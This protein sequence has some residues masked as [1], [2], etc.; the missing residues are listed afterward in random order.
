[1]EKDFDIKEIQKDLNEYF[2]KK[3]GRRIQFAGFGPVQ[4]PAENKS[5]EGSKERSKEPLSINFDMKPEELEVASALQVK[6][7]FLLDPL[8]RWLEHD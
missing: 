2:E 3:Y 5:E 8:W 6:H 1:M 4:E 7:R